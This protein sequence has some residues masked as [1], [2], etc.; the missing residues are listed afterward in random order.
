MKFDNSKV[1]FLEKEVKIM[2]IKFADDIIKEIINRDKIPVKNDCATGEEFEKWLRSENM[3]DE[4]KVNKII[5]LLQSH[6]LDDYECCIEIAKVV[7]IYNYER[8]D[9][10]D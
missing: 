1:R 6:D 3:S 2:P 10:R 4:E 9:N 7:G 5:E 8:E